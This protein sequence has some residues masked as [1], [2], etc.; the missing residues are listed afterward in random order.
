[1]SLLDVQNFLARIYT[2]ENLRREF[3]TAPEEI[4]R[5]NNLSER[6]INELTAVFPDELNSF[7]DSLRLKRLREVEKLLPLTRAQ[8]NGEF[9]RHFREFSDSFNSQSIKKHLADALH[10]CDYLR[11]NKAV[12]ARAKNA[13]KYERAKLEFWA[14]NRRFVWRIFDFNIATGEPKKHIGV[15]FKIGK[16]EFIF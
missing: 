13:A 16:R 12:S 1:M 14:L 15:W 6:E 2:N 4:G 11:A 8:L 9:E 7:A 5:E 10:F 3:L